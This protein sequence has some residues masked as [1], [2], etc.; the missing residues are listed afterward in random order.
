M[1]DRLSRS[2]KRFERLT[3]AQKAVPI[4]DRLFLVNAI[5]CRRLINRSLLIDIAQAIWVMDCHC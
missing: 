5:G 2:G 1:L 3:N 4:A